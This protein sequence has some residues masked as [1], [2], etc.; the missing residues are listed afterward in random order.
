[1][2]T[3]DLT[4]QGSGEF[5]TLSMVRTLQ[6]MMGF[7]E[8]G[9]GITRRIDS[10]H[11]LA[12]ENEMIYRKSCDILFQALDF[13][14]SIELDIR[15]RSAGELSTGEILEL[16]GELRVVRKFINKLNEILESETFA[17]QTR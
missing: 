16:R 9:E 4:C 6:E 12:F 3:V 14:D 10:V 11:S 17:K 15:E 13:A 8:T 7:V 2:G 1:M 5:P